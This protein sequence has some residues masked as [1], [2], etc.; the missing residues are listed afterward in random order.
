MLNFFYISLV[1][2]QLSCVELDAYRILH[3]NYNLINVSNK[4]MY[5]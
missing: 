4:A 1:S 2:L 5:M 3:N